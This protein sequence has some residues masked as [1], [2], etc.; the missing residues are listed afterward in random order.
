[1]SAESRHISPAEYLDIERSAERKSEFHD[2]RIVARDSANVNHCQLQIS[3]S[4]TLYPQARRRGCWGFL[5]DMRVAIPA[6]R[7]YVYP[8]LTVVCGEPQFD[9][10]QQDTLLNP[11]VIIEILSPSTAM[12]DRTDKFARYR[13]IPTLRE[14]L[15]VAQDAPQIEHF[16]RQQDDQWLWS[17]AET[18]E[19]TVTLPSIDCT[20]ALADI[21]AGLTLG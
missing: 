11:T 18:L 13:R 20:I 5:S 7:S 14:Y 8:D 16:V 10:D 1:M 19:E 3:L 9:D 2:G 4:M 15:L 12:Q 21:Y 6:R 17:I